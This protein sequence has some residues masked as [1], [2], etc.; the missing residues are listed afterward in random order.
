MTLEI[1]SNIEYRQLSYMLFVLYLISS[2]SCEGRE[3]KSKVKAAGGGA[4]ILYQF[5]LLAAGLAFLLGQLSHLLLQVPDLSLHA[6]VLL[7]LPILPGH[8]LVALLHHLLQVLLQTRHQALRRRELLRCLCT[9]SR[10]HST[11]ILTVR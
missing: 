6:L 3:F 11:V 4:S 5:M 2:Q 10:L 9:P 8:P 1:Y 7:L